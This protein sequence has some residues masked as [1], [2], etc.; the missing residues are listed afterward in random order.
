MQSEEV[1]LNI[2]IELN[3]CKIF[4]GVCITSGIVPS[5]NLWT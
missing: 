3:S 4:P 2:V 1:F 5:Q